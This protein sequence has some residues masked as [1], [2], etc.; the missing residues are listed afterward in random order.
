MN[1]TKL[2]SHV[3]TIRQAFGYINKFKGETFVIML[4]DILLQDPGFHILISD[5]ILLNKMGIKIAIVPGAKNRID[6]ILSSFDIDYNYENNIRISSEESIQFIKMAAFDVCN[7]IMTIISE[8]NADGCIGN[9]T[10]A[11]AIGVR[12]GTDYQTTGLVEKINRKIPIMLLEDGIIPIFPNI[13]W[14]LTGKPYNISSNELAL[15]TSTAL[16][17]SK[18]FF[19]TD[20]DHFSEDRIKVPEGLKNGDQGKISN[21]TP[22]EAEEIIKVNDTFSDDINILS[23][24]YEACSKGVERVHIVNGTKEGTL[25]KEIFSDTGLGTMIYSDQYENIRKIKKKDI[26]Q[27]LNIINRYSE[28]GALLKRSE[29]DILSNI[30]NFYVFERDNIVHATGGIRYYPDS[31]AE[32]MG[33]GVDED[34][35]NLGTGKKIVNYLIEKARKEGYTRIFLLTT[36]AYDWFQQIG[37]REGKITE[38]PEE[39]QDHYNRERNSRILVLE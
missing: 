4:D 15:R 18:L 32:I 35:K 14:N 38:L 6:K 5:I 23:N 10:K 16:G 9:W 26:P 12:N 13:G 8:N 2:S 20:S 11:R 7:H 19:L 28:S 1:E 24:A 37:F 22:S 3:D 34:Y 36:H 30:E 39:K 21:L 27:A 33:I 31:S 25:L 29:Q 17:A